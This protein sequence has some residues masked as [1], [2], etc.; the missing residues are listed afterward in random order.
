[1][2]SATMKFWHFLRDEEGASAVEYSVLI[3]LIILVAIASVYLLGQ[4][5]KQGFDKFMEAFL[6]VKPS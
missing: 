2:K 1:M 3:V 4:E 6:G 5:V